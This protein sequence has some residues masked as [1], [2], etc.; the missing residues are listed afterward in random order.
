MKNTYYVPPVAEEIHLAL[1][2]LIAQSP[3]G[4]L[5]DMPGDVIFDSS[6]L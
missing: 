3:G 4:S 5:E 2:G 6:Q 1:E